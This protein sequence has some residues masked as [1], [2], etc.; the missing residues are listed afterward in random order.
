MLGLFL[1]GQHP[2][3]WCWLDVLLGLWK[4]GFPYAKKKLSRALDCS[5]RS[6]EGPYF[7]CSVVRVWLRWA[8]LVGTP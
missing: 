2:A 3:I 1:K 5:S 4:Q 6:P 7:G 8:E